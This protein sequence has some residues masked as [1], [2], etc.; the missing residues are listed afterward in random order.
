MNP[1]GIYTLLTADASLVA[2]MNHAVDAVLQK[3][4]KINL[5]FMLPGFFAFEDRV[6]IKK[7][8]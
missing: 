6:D 2:D 5:L 7:R 3:E 1:A 4:Q 8:S